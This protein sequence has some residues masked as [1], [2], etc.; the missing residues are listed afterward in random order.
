MPPSRRRLLR[1]AG[2]AL[3]AASASGC[4]D[5]GSDPTASDPSAGEP[6][7]A[8]SPTPT[9]TS[10]P[11]ELTST[12]TAGSVGAETATTPTASSFETTN[13]SYGKWLPTPAAAGIFRRE[14]YIF[15]SVAPGPLLANRDRVSE[16]LVS[17]AEFDSFV[18][19]VDSSEDITAGTRVLK[20][21]TVVETTYDRDGAVA[22]AEERGYTR[23]EPHRGFAIRSNDSGATLAFGDGV[24]VVSGVSGTAYEGEK[25]PRIEAVIDAGTGNAP[26]YGEDVDGCGRL[27]DAL[28]PAHLATGAPHRRGA[29][30]EGAV[31]VGKSARLGPERTLLRAPVVFAEGAVDR[32]A[33]GEWA[34]NAGLFDDAEPTTAVDGR[35][36][37]ARA[38]V[39]TESF[40]GFTSTLP[41]HGSER[42]ATPE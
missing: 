19:G 30:F 5:S 8:T 6:D 17:R 41:A 27:L 22:T 15:T 10:A 1:R 16:S 32:E 7:D 40:T 24:I 18:P 12:P 2:A 33:V 3:L 28:G 35:T 37:V 13:E 14:D 42:T 20:G 39:P 21:W 29:S 25:R 23:D 36:V 38:L 31:A 34:A 4:L 11:G 9:A 26:R